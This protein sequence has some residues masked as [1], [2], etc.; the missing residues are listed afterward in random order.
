[1][2][3]FVERHKAILKASMQGVLE[4]EQKLQQL[5]DWWGKVSLIG[6]INSLRLG[7]D[8]LTSMDITKQRFNQLQHTLIDNLLQEQTKKVLL[9][10][11]ACC[12]MA[13]DVLI[14]NLFERTADIGFLATDQQIC[15]FMAQP[16][17]DEALQNRLHQHLQH[18]VAN[19]SVY[20]DV[21]LLGLDGTILLRLN[22]QYKQ[23]HSA[24]PLLQH[25]LE[26]GSNYTETCRYS[27]L[28][29]DKSLSLIYSQPVYSDA[30]QPFGVL[31]LCFNIA[32][33]LN[34]IFSKLLAANRHSILALVNADGTVAF[35][36]DP[37]QL[38]AQ[39]RV[40]VA[41]YLNVQQHGH[42]SYL[43]SFANSRGYQQYFGPGWQ[44]QM[45]TP[46]QQLANSKVNAG[47]TDSPSDGQLF[48]A[49]L[50][51]KRESMQVNDELSLIVLN[52]EIAAAR[53]E[54]IEFIPVLNAIRGIGQNIYQVFSSSIDELGSTI[55]HSLLQE[56]TTLAELA[57]DI[58]DRN[59]YE[60]ANDCRWWA[61]NASFRRVLA[62]N[63]VDATQRQELSAE[64]SYINNLYT[65]YHTIYLYNAAQ[66]L[67]AISTAGTHITNIDDSTGAA[68][69]LQLTQ[70]QQYSV[71]AFVPSALYRQQATYI[72]NAPLFHPAEPEQVIGGIG[73]VFDSTP[74]FRAML[75]DILP[76]NEQGDIKTGYSACYVDSAGK[77][78]SAS[79]DN[80]QIGAR[81][82]LPAAL[83][84]RALQGSITEQ[85][86]INGQRYLLAIAPANGYR[87]YKTS[88]GYKN[89]VFACL[90]LNYH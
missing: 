46:L 73:L 24:D 10:D 33:E 36:S 44:V 39:T 31:C 17:A 54:A 52:G 71:S 81:L 9:H 32:D 23:T 58:M 63:T 51:I 16:M 1:M 82:P 74:Q 49:L 77:I 78:I 83:Y 19:Y 15:H 87:E 56:L 66:Q 2:Q 5:D 60:R 37:V 20:D 26:R 53:K 47:N 45:W 42:H 4:H 21:V 59:L 75:I 38:A 61:Q 67:V 50:A 35:S 41:N 8:I 29:P 89:V 62:Q 57:A 12:Q 70:P 88:D 65:V 11:N 28:Q 18:Y 43:V 86:D 69:C 3:L 68:G 79:H 30:S 72:Y 25:S 22:Q 6:K 85:C 40:A 48:P 34:T 84:Q 7:S 55:M 90:L 64:L 13:I 14:R 76:K 27:D 80:W